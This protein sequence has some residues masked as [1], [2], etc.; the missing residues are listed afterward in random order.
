MRTAVIGL[1]LVLVIGVLG[2]LVRVP[3]VAL[4]P[5]PTFD[6]LGMVDGKT[7][8]AVD[9]LPTYPTEGQLNMTTVAVTDGLNLIN[10]L[11]FWV[12]EDQRLVPR[13]TIYPPGKTDQQ[14]QREN[15]RLFAASED[16]AEVA[17]LRYLGL[18]T[19]VVVA[20]VTPEAPAAG[21]LEE[22]DQL[23]AVNGQPVD[24]AGEVSEILKATRPG[25][26]VAV[27]FAR[28]DEPPR[29]GT[30]TVGSR[31]DGAPQGFF[32]IV[33]SGEPRNPD[34]ITISL[35]DVGG[36]SAGLPFALA[37]VD[38]LTPGALTDGQFVA[39]TGTIT[40]TG[41]VGPIGGIP[42]KMQAASEAGATVFLVP[43]ANC[44]EARATAPEDLRLVE[45][46]TL[47]GAVDALN[48]LAAGGQPPTC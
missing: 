4:G 6:T 40:P 12:A 7:V 31:P 48:T 9:G 42:L 21:V 44:A 2:A 14:V 25:D 17:A 38:K 34:Q 46:G 45:V 23:L 39:G 18:P 28:G 15:S 8:V 16:I 41:Q 27:T 26:E 29:T 43:E 35:G 37:V 36:P 10:A 33:P 24:E 32:G 20:E 30:V 3:L 5:G 22:G 13:A 19:T 1:L 47:A 11:G